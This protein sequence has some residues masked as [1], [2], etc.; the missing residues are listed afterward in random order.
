MI[1]LWCVPGGEILAAGRGRAD[2]GAPIVDRTGEEDVRNVHL[3]SRRLS[4]R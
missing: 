2:D 1:L 4:R 3:W